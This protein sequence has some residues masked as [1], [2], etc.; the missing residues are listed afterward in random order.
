MNFGERLKNLRLSKN[1]TATKLAAMSQVARMTISRIERRGE[2]PNLSTVLKL[3]SA[4]G[5]EPSILL[6]TQDD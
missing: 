6:G 2:Q 1:L 5:V 3:A 4:L